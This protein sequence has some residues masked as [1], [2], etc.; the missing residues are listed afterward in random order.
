[1]IVWSLFASEIMNRR[2]IVK[3]AFLA[4]AVIASTPSVNATVPSVCLVEDPTTTPL[5]LRA[6]PSGRI[7]G[8]LG[9]GST[10]QVID[11]AQ[12]KNGKPWAYVADRSDQPLGWVFR[13]YLVC[14]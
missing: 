7:F 12:D 3:V 2:L 11:G 13:E 5:N 4:L 8:V 9:N 10:V 1:L 6:A 14:R